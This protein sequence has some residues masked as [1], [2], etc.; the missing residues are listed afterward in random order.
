MRVRCWRQGSRRRV[1]LLRA[2]AKPITRQRVW[3]MVNARLGAIG[4]HASPH[5]LRHSCATHMVE[6]GADLRTVQTILGHADISTTQVYTHL[7][8]DRLNKGVQAAPSAEQGT[9]DAD[10]LRTRRMTKP[11]ATIVEKAIAKFIRALQERNASPHT[12]KAY[13]HRSGAVRG[14]RRAAGAGATSTTF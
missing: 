14:L 7:A 2:G 1:C 13:S 5:M 8:L 10:Q 6:N 4:R 12:I 11:G 9:L 3:Q